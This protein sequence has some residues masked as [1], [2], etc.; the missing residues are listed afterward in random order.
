M[1][2]ITFRNLH[3]GGSGENLNF[4]GS[5][6]LMTECMLPIVHIWYIAMKF[7]NVLEYMLFLV[8]V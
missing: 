5:V 2:G 1:I 6:S 4:W 3:F 7:R 8:L